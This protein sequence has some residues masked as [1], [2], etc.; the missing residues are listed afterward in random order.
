MSCTRCARAS[1]VRLRVRAP[2]RAKLLDAAREASRPRGTKRRQVETPEIWVR[3]ARDTS[4]SRP[5]CFRAAP[6]PWPRGTKRRWRRLSLA[7]R[8]G[9]RGTKG[10]PCARAARSGILARGMTSTRAM[11]RACGLRR[12]TSRSLGDRRSP[13]S[14]SQPRR[15]TANRTWPKVSLSETREACGT[16]CM[17]LRGRA[18]PCRRSNSDGTSCTQRARR[19]P[20]AWLRPS[21]SGERCGSRCTVP[22]WHRGSDARLYGNSHI[23]LPEAPS[24]RVACGMKR[25]AYAVRR[26]QRRHVNWSGGVLC[27][28]GTRRMQWRLP[29]YRGGCG[30]S[31]TR[32]ARLP[33]RSLGDPRGTKCTA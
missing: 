5:R 25:I 26:T 20:C 2:D 24:G 29:A 12:G 16:T 30:M 15:G 19:G 10:R 9:L 31:Y 18:A 14:S 27:R 3:A 11:A 21:A 32:D 7:F 33:L 8:H 4:R 6:T 1:I 22:R 28:H 23:D 17:R 13:V